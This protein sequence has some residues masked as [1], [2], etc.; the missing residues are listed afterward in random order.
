M[1]NRSPCMGMKMS[2]CEKHHLKWMTGGYICS[3]DKYEQSWNDDSLNCKWA[4]VY[5]CHLETFV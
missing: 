5:G 1:E 3:R 4:S 2:Y